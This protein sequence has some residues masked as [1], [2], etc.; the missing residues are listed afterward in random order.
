MSAIQYSEHVFVLEKKPCRFII[1]FNI[2]L[3]LII[4]S[5]VEGKNKYI[6]EEEEEEGRL[7]AMMELIPNSVSY[8]PIV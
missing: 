8:L 7:E 4:D 6:N 1:R 3:Y 2:K 5:F